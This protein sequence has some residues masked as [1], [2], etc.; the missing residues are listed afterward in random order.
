MHEYRPINCEFH[1]VLE[2]LATTK[3]TARIEY[4]DQDDSV[5]SQDDVIVDVY[6]RDGAEFIDLRSGCTVRLD[7]LVAVNGSKET[8]F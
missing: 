3:S 5:V 4:R 1:D 7:R 6:A 2:A 8:D